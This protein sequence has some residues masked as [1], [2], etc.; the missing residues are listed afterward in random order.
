MKR[1]IHR[2]C[3]EKDLLLFHYGEL[4]TVARQRMQQHL[5]DCQGCR[6]RL[7]TLQQHLADLPLPGIVLSDVDKHRMA[8]IITDRAAHRQRPKRWIWG[9]ALAAGAVLAMSLFIIPG[10]PGNFPG[11]L[12][13]SE[14]ELGMLQDL[15]LLQNIELLENMDLLQDLERIG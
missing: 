8:A 9:S 4:D 6:D 3:N 5:D 12:P 2:N 14:T 15:E 11:S 7:A 1:R 10:G 13:R